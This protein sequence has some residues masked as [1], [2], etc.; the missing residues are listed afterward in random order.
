MGHSYLARKSSL[1]LPSEMNSIL[2][3]PSL[4]LQSKWQMGWDWGG[5]RGER[6][7]HSYDEKDEKERVRRHF[8]AISLMRTLSMLR[9]RP[10]KQRNE[11]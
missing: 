10:R 8:H 1:V 11:M 7:L 5:S 4:D 9:L 2:S 6:R 3:Q